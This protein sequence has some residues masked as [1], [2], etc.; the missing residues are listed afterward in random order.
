MSLWLVRCWPP[1][2]AERL[3]GLVLLGELALDGRLRPVRGVPP[4][5]LAAR[6]VGIG[7]VVVPTASLA[8]AALV[9]GRGC[10][11]RSAGHTRRRCRR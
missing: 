5:V 2:P 4:A 8:E 7:Q 11:A 10:T 9:D 1:D 6:Q 3:R